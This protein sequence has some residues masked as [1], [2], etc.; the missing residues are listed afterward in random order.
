MM[1]RNGH[2]VG[3]ISRQINDMAAEALGIGPRHAIRPGPSRV[4]D[5][6]GSSGK[7]R[8]LGRV[9][10]CPSA[11]Y[12][13][14]IRDCGRGATVKRGG[15]VAG[16]TV[17]FRRGAFG[18]VD[19]TGGVRAESPTLG[20]FAEGTPIDVGAGPVAFGAFNGSLRNLSVTREEGV[21]DIGKAGA[22]D[23]ETRTAGRNS[24][25]VAG[26]VFTHMDPVDQKFKVEGD[27]VNR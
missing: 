21:A 8:E 7:L 23:S 9:S 13:R 6:A 11:Y 2:L 12:G 26:Q 14:R 3:V 27:A 25:R 18:C 15:I 22:L 19:L 5:G 16:G 4:G 17:F 24:R 10:C 20:I 1:A